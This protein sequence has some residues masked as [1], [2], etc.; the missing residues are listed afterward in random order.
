MRFLGLH[1]ITF[2]SLPEVACFELKVVIHLLALP[3]FSNL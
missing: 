1:N 3:G 2:T